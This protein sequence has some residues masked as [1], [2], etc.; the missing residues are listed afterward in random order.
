MVNYRYAIRASKRDTIFNRFFFQRSDHSRKVLPFQNSHHPL[1]SRYLGRCLES[2]MN[3]DRKSRVRRKNALKRA[4]KGVDKKDARRRACM[5]GSG[6]VCVYIYTCMYTSSYR[7]GSPATGFNLATRG[8]R[9]GGGGTIGR[10]RRRR[11][12]R[13]LIFIRPANNRFAANSPPSFRFWLE[14][15]RRVFL[16]FSKEP[17]LCSFTIVHIHW[18][19]G[20]IFENVDLVKSCEESWQ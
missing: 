11:R 1:A 7:H 20:G 9:G 18:N 2:A 19:R 13:T 12:V 8:T 5:D 14:I 15:S 17:A 4:A 6:C 10:R 16:F 3:R